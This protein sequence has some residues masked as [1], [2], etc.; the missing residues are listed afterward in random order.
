MDAVLIQTLLVA[1]LF[2]IESLWPFYHGR[3]KRVVHG[4]RNLTLALL[5]G[6]IGSLLFASLIAASASWS[7]TESIGLL[8]KLTLPNWL[9]L[10][11]ALLC[12]DCWMYWWHRINHL[13]PLLWR[14][15][16]VHH[17]DPEMDVTTGL[18]FHPGELILS[19]L[20]RLLVVPLLGVTLAELIIYQIIAQ[21][22]VLFHHSNIAVPHGIDRA[23]RAILV[24]PNMH[25]VHHSVIVSE[26]NSNYSS[27][28]SIWDWVFG[29]YRY[30]DDPQAI[31][32]GLEQF[33]D[34][35]AQSVPGML[36]TPFKNS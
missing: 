30:R 32:L 8:H 2:L 24:S 23:I 14:F 26:T 10:I 36:E 1:A 35:N 29:S 17:S 13:V 27:V 34:S 20:A 7:A 22:I 3:S 5:N 9:H 18:R 25:R 6:V 33:R 28:L 12:F 4:A 19:H 31:V 15:H 16:R 21:S 11:L